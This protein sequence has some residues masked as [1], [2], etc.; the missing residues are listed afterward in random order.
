[1]AKDIKVV[2][3]NATQTGDFKQGNSD[4][5]T[6]EAMETAVLMSWFTNKRAT[7]DEVD[8]PED[9]QGWWGDQV[10]EV[11][12]DE[13]GSKLWL[14]RRAKNTPENVEKARIYATEALEWMVEDGVSQEVIVEARGEKNV[15]GDRLYLKAEILKGDG[16]TFAFKYDILWENL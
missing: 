12:A 15:N 2:W 9:R 8:D 16:T 6:D 3:D 4:L 11:E 10:S 7:L 1:M 13:I 5:V 14:L